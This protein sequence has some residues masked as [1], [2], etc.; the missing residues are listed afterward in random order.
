MRGG[1]FEDADAYPASEKDARLNFTS[2]NG[3]TTTSEIEWEVSFAQ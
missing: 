1:R 2:S 3:M